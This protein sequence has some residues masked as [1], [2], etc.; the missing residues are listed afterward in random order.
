MP[1]LLD[2]ASAEF[3]RAFAAFLAM[4]R[5]VAADVANGY[6]SAPAARRDYDFDDTQNSAAE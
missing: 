4:K 1:V 3:G 5:E 6:V 2:T